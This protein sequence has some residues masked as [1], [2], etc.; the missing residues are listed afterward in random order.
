VRDG[1]GGN[2]QFGGLELDA[3]DDAQVR[4]VVADEVWSTVC[5]RRSSKQQARGR[6][7]E[8]RVGYLACSGYGI[9][10]GSSSSPIQFHF[11]RSKQSVDGQSD[12]GAGRPPFDGRSVL[13][14]AR[15]STN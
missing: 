7:E 4:L 11:G 6:F 2:G 12:E 15:P 1:G 5:G 14:V 3:V 10:G 9:A 8:A 13:H